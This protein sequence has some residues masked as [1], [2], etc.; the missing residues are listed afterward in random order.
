MI[1][2]PMIVNLKKRRRGCLMLLMLVPRKQQK[3]M[4]PVTLAK[5]KVMRIALMKV[6]KSLRVKRLRLPLLQSQMQKQLRMIAAVTTEALTLM[7]RK[8][9]VSRPRRLQLLPMAQR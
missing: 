2:L 1:V 6:M 4:N 9:R 3:R 7:R 5:M 8:P